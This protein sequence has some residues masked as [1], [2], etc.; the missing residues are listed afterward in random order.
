MHER[1]LYSALKKNRLAGAALDVFELEPYMGP[2]KELDNIIL[3][4][5]VGS[6]AKETRINM[7]RQAVKNLI[8]GF[9]NI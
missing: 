8:N 6:F 7:E 2:L 3:T 4:P 9:K 1:A 5:H